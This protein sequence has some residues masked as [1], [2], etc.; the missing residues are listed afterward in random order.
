MRGI[1]IFPSRRASNMGLCRLFVA[2]LNKLFKKQ[3]RVGDAFTLSDITVMHCYLF[4]GTP[5]AGTQSPSEHQCCQRQPNGNQDAWASL[6]HWGQETMAAIF[7]IQSS[8][9]ITWC[10][11]VRYCINNYGNS[12]R[13][14]IRCWFHKRHPIPHPNGRAMGC[15]LWIF[16]RKLT[17]S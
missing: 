12:D 1:N 2:S 5:S 11:I 15:L 8:A 4:E 7:H 10:N 3:L 13:I 9:V 14:S 16:V 17:A 6:T